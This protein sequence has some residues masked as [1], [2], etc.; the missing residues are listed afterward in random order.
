[1]V[2]YRPPIDIPQQKLSLYWHRRQDR[3]ASHRWMRGQVLDM[4]RVLDPMVDA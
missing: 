1:V 3:S 2:I 4:A